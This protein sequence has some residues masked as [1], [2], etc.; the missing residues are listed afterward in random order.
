MS[1][2]CLT[3]SHIQNFYIFISNLSPTF[4]LSGHSNIRTDS[5]QLSCAESPD[6]LKHPKSLKFRW[7]LRP[8]SHQALLFWPQWI[9]DFPAWTASK[10]FFP[11]FH[12][13]GVFCVPD[14][15][16][17]VCCLRWET[18]FSCW[19]GCSSDLQIIPWARRGRA[20]C[21]LWSRSSRLS[22]VFLQRDAPLFTF[23]F[24][25]CFSLSFSLLSGT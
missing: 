2:T 13:A 23:F 22:S 24:Y 18:C 19:E 4:P 6:A 8:L 12:G 7:I 20:F 1:N 10:Y 21:A 11:T 17:S 3:E 9:Q 14:S 25:L 16:G 5:E 15:W